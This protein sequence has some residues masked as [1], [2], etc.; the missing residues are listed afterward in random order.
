MAQKGPDTLLNGIALCGV[1]HWM[2]DRGLMSIDDDFSLLFNSKSVP[3]KV[4]RM[5]NREQ[6]LLLPKSNK[7]Y[8]HRIFLKWHRDNVFKP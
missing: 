1:A 8:P 5:V 6:R 2:F 7:S 3:D 4:M